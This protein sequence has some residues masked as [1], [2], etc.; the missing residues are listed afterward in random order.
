MADTLQTAYERY[1]AADG[2]TDRRNEIAQIGFRLARRLG[3]ETVYPFDYRMGIGNDSIGAYLGRNPDAAR[4]R[5]ARSQEIQQSLVAED[6]LLRRV[7][8]VEYYR[9]INSEERI[10]S[11]N[12]LMYR[13]I[14]LGDGAN[15]GGP[16]MLSRW[17]DRNFR[18]V[19]HLTRLSDDAG[20]R[21]LVLVGSGHVLPLRHILD[22]SPGLCPVSPLPYLS[23]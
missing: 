1:L 19:H 22:V 10:R 8:L 21:V 2:E 12:E 15:Y 4:A 3:H 20:N 14:A 18:M 9:Y 5:A 17:Y 7:G 6:S 13:A 11:G 23:G 16:R